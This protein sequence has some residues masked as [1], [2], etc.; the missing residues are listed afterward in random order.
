MAGEAA[1]YA[2]YVGDLVYRKKIAAGLEP[3]N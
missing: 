2:G 1:G 3:L